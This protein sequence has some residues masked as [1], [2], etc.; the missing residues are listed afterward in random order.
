M[1]I[2][3][4]SSDVCSSDLVTGLESGWYTLLPARYAM[5][6][7]GFRIVEQTGYQA[8]AG[9]TGKLYDGTLVTTG[10]YG[11]AGAGLRES[12]LR[13]FSVQSQQVFRKYSNI[14]LTSA[15]KLF[16]DRAARNAVA[17]PRLPVDAGV[18]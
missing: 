16:A 12:T 2:S 4:W 5:L 18:R 1:R 3:D 13:A 7:G 9:A 15:N 17:A 6:P 10:Y 14:A 8:V 11:V